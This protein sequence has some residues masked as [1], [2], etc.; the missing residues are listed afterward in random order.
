VFDRFAAIALDTMRADVVSIWLTNGDERQLTLEAQTGVLRP[1]V[2]LGHQP[3]R[4]KGLT[5]FILDGGRSLAIEDLPGDSR[6]WN[7]AWYD[8]QGIRSFLGVP[9]C[10]NGTALGVMVCLTRTTRQ[11]SPDDVA[12]GEAL[13]TAA[14]VYVEM[15]EQLDQNATIL[16]VARD[17]NSTLDFAEVMRRVARTTGR[18]LGVDMVGAYLPDEEGTAL[19]P[20]AGYHVPRHLLQRFLDFPLE[21]R[22][23]SYIEEG[24]RSLQPTWCHD[25]RT[26]GTIDPALIE[27]API[28][29]VFFFPLVVKDHAIGALI[30][31]WWEP[32]PAPTPRER[33]LL[34]GIARQTALAIG[35]ARLFE[36]RV[37]DAQRLQGLNEMS[38][39]LTAILDPR[40][41]VGTIAKF[42]AELLDARLVRLW[43]LDRASG[44]LVLVASAGPDAAEAAEVTAVVRIAQGTAIIGSIF[45][46]RTSEFIRDI[47]QDGRW[48][49]RALGER[50][51]LRGFA[52]A[53]LVLGDEVFG[54][55]SIMMRRPGDFSEGQ[56][57]L[58]GAFTAQAALALQNARIFDDQQRRL[59]ET[60]ALLGVADSLAHTRDIGE[61]MRRVCRE[62]TRAL[63]AD[64]G[65]FYTVDEQGQNVIPV[66]GYHIPK[67][68]L[69]DSRPLPVDAVPQPMRD[70]RSAREV[71]FVPDV[72]MDPRF[73]MAALKALGARSLLSS[74]IVAQ[75]RFVGDVQVYWRDRV[76]QVSDGDRA[77]MAA[78]SAQ[79]ALAL[80]NARLLVE[81]QSAASR[82]QEKN[83]ELDSFVYT[84][85]HDLKAPLVT[86][87]GMSG[88]VLEEYTD[89]L[90][91]DGRHYLERIVANTQQ[92]E[93]LILDLLALSRSGREGQPPQEVDLAEVVDECV[94]ALAERLEARSIKVAVGDLPRVWA[95]RVQMD[96][97]F[98][99]LMTNAIKYMGDTEAPAIEIGAMTRPSEFEIWVRD[100]GIG[101]D[102]AYH[103]KVF[104]IF[105]R[106]KEVEAEGS[107]VGL[108]IVKKIVQGAGGRIWVESAPGQGSTFRF[109]WPAASRR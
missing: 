44:E 32:R 61:I 11:W 49:N 60:E 1:D 5:G 57:Q 94:A 95:V 12:K 36:E 29:S 35:N 76:H 109:T 51:G 9:L 80:E 14:A 31:I 25:A 3:E 6:V 107:G 108:P 72:P 34:E 93:R 54:V 22:R 96:Q 7:R 91:D 78:I 10:L 102:A 33:H 71:L 55:L 15:R 43:T 103:E 82:L 100:T 89:K 42:A 20:V 45:A 2:A 13:A 37:R 38:R 8:A 98:K 101:I 84:V 53:P 40:E 105:Q 81:T 59:R 64:C 24:W 92:M 79:A 16:E 88:M 73:E 106:L 97:V 62:A 50:L 4:D 70:A 68:V 83:A 17:A 87:Q 21:I 58:I 66:A 86:I 75:D 30:L 46:T 18:A 23:T 74:P 28:R 63:G 90:D 41:I 65:V 69:A 27:W 19:R 104:E 47:N 56:R 48:R 39:R 67:D 77:L 99:N 52:G 26:D 85:S